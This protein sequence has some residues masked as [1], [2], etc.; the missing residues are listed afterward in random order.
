MP[1][2]SA[3]IE[4]FALRNHFTIS[5][6]SKTET[7]VVTATVSDG[8]VSGRGECGPNARY[9]ETPESVHAAILDCAGD[10]ADGLDRRAL[11][12]RMPPGA[13]RNAIDCALWD[14]ESK[15]AGCPA[16]Q[17]AGLEAPQ[18]VDTAFTLSVD[19]PDAMARAALQNATRPVLKLKLT[20]E[21]DI[22]RVSAVREAA[23][24][25]DLIVD[26]NEAWDIAA[27]EACVPAFDGMGVKL[28]EQPFPAGDDAALATLDRPIPVCADE[29][30]HDTETLGPLAGRYDVVNIKLDKT[31]G[32]TEALTAATA[33][34]QAGFDVMV[35]CMV[36]TSLAMAPA[37]LVAQGARFVDLDGPL[38]LAEDR[39]PSLPV[40]GSRL[41]APPRALWG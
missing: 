36:G 20:G 12:D 18:P 15:R 23:P 13:A 26:A 5:R 17:L 35:G 2:L 27:Y 14:F 29:S 41:S 21:D 16:W 11:L 37:F 25:P 39:E 3:S 4:T 24:E 30:F 33:A 34:R 28:I 9:G 22:A 31:G 7:V 10:V 19:T 6:G 40:I 8:R 1:G 38:L 32:L